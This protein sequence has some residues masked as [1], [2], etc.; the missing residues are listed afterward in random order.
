MSDININTYQLSQYADRIRSVCSRSD[1][2]DWRL[3]KLYSS[4]GLRDLYSLLRKVDF[5]DYKWKL[6]ECRNYLLQTASDFE[7]TENHLGMFDPS[8]FTPPISNLPIFNPFTSKRDLWSSHLRGVQEAF[9]NSSPG[10]IGFGIAGSALDLMHKDAIK[11]FWDGK[12]SASA[13]GSVWSDVSEDGESYIKVLNGEVSASVGP[14]Y[15]EYKNKKVKKISKQDDIDVPWKKDNLP[16]EKWYKQTGTILEATAGA[17]ITGSVLDGRIAGDN[18]WAEGSV[19]AKLLTG[20]AHANVGAGLYVYEADKNGNVKRIFSPGVNAEVG[21]S[22]AVVQVEAE[23]SI[24]L[25]KDKKMLGAYG[26]A[27]VGALTA[28]AKAKVSLNS[29]EIYAGASAE[30]D[31][32]KISGSAGVSVLGTDIGVNGSLKVGVGAHAEIGYTDGKLKVDIGAAV[33]V[34]F[35]LGFEVDVSGTVDAVCD[36]AESAWDGAKNIASGAW[37]WLFG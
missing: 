15:G 25:G 27:E 4:T 29:N 28:E 5:T 10:I 20:E 7:Y 33:G 36:L 24:G 26:N 16:D 18:G 1:G 14:K 2:I 3:R 8:S 35:D 13:N 9:R 23:G 11:D 37:N 17:S 32:V 22:V 19:E 30:A 6:S 34:G 21:A 12:Y 31:L